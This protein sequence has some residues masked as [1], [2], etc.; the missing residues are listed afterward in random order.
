MGE[1]IHA[2]TIVQIGQPIPESSIV[3]GNMI[4]PAFVP[5]CNGLGRGTI[6][7]VLGLCGQMDLGTS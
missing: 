6:A 3:C 2:R 5:V 4:A 1:Q 7:Q